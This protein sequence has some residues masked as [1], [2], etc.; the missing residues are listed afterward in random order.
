MS[1]EGFASCGADAI[2]VKLRLSGLLVAQKIEY[3]WNPRYA[4]P[5]NQSGL[6]TIES[7][8]AG[9]WS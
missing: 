6:M 3:Q 2:G 9:C 4:S 5:N 8:M 7:D 1:R